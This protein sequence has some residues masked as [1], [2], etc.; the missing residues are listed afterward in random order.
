[1]KTVEKVVNPVRRAGEQSPGKIYDEKLK[2]RARREWRGVKD[3]FYDYTRWLYLMSVLGRFIMV[4]RN[5]KGFFRYRWMMSYL[6]VPHGMDKFT[7]GLRDEALRIAH[8]SFNFVIADV[9]QAIANCFRGDRRVGNDKAYSDKCVITDE[10]SMVTFMMGFDR[11]K[12]HTILR[13]VPTM[14]ASN[15]FHQF[16]VM[17]YLDIAQQYG[18]PGDVCPMPEAEAGISIEDDFCVLGC[19]A[20]QNNTTCDGSLMGNGIIA[21]RLDREYGIP[22]FQLATPLRH[23]EPDVLEYAAQE[24]KNAI[25]FV[26]EHTGE[27][28]DWKLYFDAAKRVNYATKCRIAQLEI[29]STPYPQFFGAAFSLYN[30]T[31]YMGNS[32]RD[33]AFVGVDK[34]LLE[35]A[36]RGYKAKRMYAKEYRHR[37]IVWG[38]QP[39]YVID[40]LYWMVQCWGVVPLADMLSIIN[41]DMIAE[42]D[43]PE[44]RE[45]AYRDM[46]M[47]NMEMIMRNHTHGGYK[48]LLDDLW[49][50]CEKMNADVVMM[51]EHMSCKALT[52]MHGMFEEQGRARG[53]HVMWVSHD[54]CDPRVFTRQAI[55]DQV[56]NY[57][58]TVMREEPLDPSL[59]NIPDN[60]AY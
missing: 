34:K 47:L 58:R 9:T 19:C 20:V 12:V 36:E 55:R 39:Q 21:K 32:G 5:V 25:A 30:D 60:E 48:V 8:T 27:K 45:Q 23:K 49:D 2:V 26:E 51:W 6:F 4:P 41:T 10:N 57:M 31:N 54:L 13:E 35:L 50:L 53:I 7:I 16:N 33:P 44:N 24:I 56:N 22:T 40:M 43:T 14:F 15:I 11:D 17:H 38:V 42:D 3:T 29:N 52:G 1:M 46:A 28:W 59:E 18:I 37:A